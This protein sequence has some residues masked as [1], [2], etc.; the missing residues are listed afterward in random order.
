M[1]GDPLLAARVDRLESAFRRIAATRMAGLSLLHPALAV[2]AV[3]F[4]RVPGEPEV[5]L[6]VLLTPWFMSLLR[7]PLSEAA[8]RG[9]PPVGA[10]RVHDC[11]PQRLEFLGADEAGLGRY[12]ASA[13][14]SPMFEFADAAAAL[15][16]A[17]AVLALLR[18]LP[19]PIAQPARR[20]FLFGRSAAGVSR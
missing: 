2:Q 5:A 1:T 15:A 16:T 9:V 3:G 6:G 20:G 11:G 4:A 19:A 17:H 10:R 18:P 13:L 7:L 14:F 8:A 12:E